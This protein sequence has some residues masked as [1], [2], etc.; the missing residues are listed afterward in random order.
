MLSFQFWMI[1]STTVNVS[2]LVVLLKSLSEITEYEMKR[3]SLNNS[4]I[5][6]FN[7]MVTHFICYF[8]DSPGDQGISII[9]NGEELL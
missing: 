8:I 2:A 6:K 7:D 4:V 3:T 9:L 1:A 5:H